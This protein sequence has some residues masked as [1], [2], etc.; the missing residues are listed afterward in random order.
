[1]AL[2]AIR[3]SFTLALKGPDVRHILRCGLRYAPLII[4]LF[5]IANGAMLLLA[6]FESES[7]VGIFRVA[8]GVAALALLPVGAFITAW[9]PLRREPIY[10]A[11]K[12]E[13][14]KQA[15]SGLLATYFVLS[16]SGSCSCSPSG[17][18]CW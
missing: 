2:V 9:G 15:A 17:R 10:A 7:E 13:R 8:A 14:G 1:M 6:Q 3:N 11:V 4:S 16:A 5:V 18:T 12:A